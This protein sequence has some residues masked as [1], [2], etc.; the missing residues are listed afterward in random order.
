[1][2][3]TN[4]LFVNV[5]SLTLQKTE[6]VVFNS[7]EDINIMLNCT[8]QRNGTEEI[9]QDEKIRWRVKVKNTFKDVAIFSRPGGYQPYIA[10][11]MEDLYKKRTELIAQTT[12]QL[13][14]VMI[15]KDPVCSDEGPYQC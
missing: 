13:S 15:I 5:S 12:S 7:N 1:M 14:A 10:F 8:Y 6:E 3:F 9:I 11:N 2:Y 4:L